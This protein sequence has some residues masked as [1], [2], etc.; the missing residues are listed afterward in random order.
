MEQVVA[1]AVATQRF[2]LQMVGVFALVALAL[3]LIGIYGVMS[4]AASRRAREIAIRAALGAGRLDNVKLLLGHGVRLI[5]AGLI[6]GGLAAAGLTRVLAGILYDVSPT[7]PATFG[8]VA[9]I[10]GLVATAACLGPARK[11]LN[12]DPMVALRQE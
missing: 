2:A 4:Y 10:L 9:A 11:A 12:I 6:V 5:A 8:V 3:A 7:D 1:A